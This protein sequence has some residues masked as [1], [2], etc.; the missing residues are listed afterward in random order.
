MSYTSYT[1]FRTAVA[2]W[3]DVSDVTTTSLDDIIQVGENYVNRKLRVELMEGALAVTINAA[4][5]ATLPSDYMEAQFLYLDR[6]PA[7]PL[8][9]K[10]AAW[11]FS[12]YAD[13]TATGVPAF[14]AETDSTFIFGPAPISADTVKGTYYARPGSLAVTQTINSV[15]S[16]YPEVYLW[17]ALANAELFLGRDQR[18]FW[19]QKVDEAI[20]RANEEDGRKK[21]SGSPISMSP[22]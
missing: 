8:T 14:V 10:S 18:L 4:G 11:I 15:F 20:N 13:R 12:N 5:A 7:A 3:L 16:S 9:K 22:G 2:S 19:Q 21:M 1:N 6:S 17:A